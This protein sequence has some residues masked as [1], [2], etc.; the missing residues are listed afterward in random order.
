MLL[1]QSLLRA[2]PIESGKIKIDDSIDIHDLDP[3]AVRSLFGVINQTPF[4]FSGTVRENIKLN[5]DQA[6]DEEILDLIQVAGLN[7]WLGRCGGLDAEV[8]EGGANFSHG[9]RQI[10]QVCRLVLSKPKVR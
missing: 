3:K 7:D 2:H 9:E 10:I 4:I 1:F 5:N 8:I 6:T